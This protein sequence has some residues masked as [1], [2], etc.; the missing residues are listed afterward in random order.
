MN[1]S[2]R[3]GCCI[4]LLLLLTIPSLI[5]GQDKK[6]LNYG[7]S[8]SAYSAIGDS[9][10][11]FW[12]YANT[13]GRVDKESANFITR[14]Y[15]HY[16][17]S[18]DNGTLRFGT[19]IDV[20]SRYS[21]SNS[22]F[23]NE[24][25]GLIGYKFLN[26]KVGR[27]YNTIGLND[28]D[29]TMGSMQVS[30]NATPVPKIELST[31]GFTDIPFTKGYVQFKTMLSHGWLEE[32]RFV[33]NA[34]LHQKYFYLKVDLDNVEL[35]GGGIH[36]V[37][38]GGDHANLGRLPSSFADFVDV[39][40][41]SSASADSNAPGSDITNAIG[42]SVA[43]YDF[44]IKVDAQ[45]FDFKAYRLFYLE[46]RVSTR[47]RSPWDGTWGAGIEF[48]EQDQ[49]VNEILWEHMNTKRQDSF[50]YEPRGSA[51]YYYNGIYRS[52]WAYQGRVL[53]NPLIT[54][55][56]NPN[57]L[58]RGDIANNIIIAH[59]LGLKGQPTDRFH[60]KVFFT[61]SRNYGTVVDQ[62]QESPTIPISE[63]RVDNYS[64]LLKGNY[65]LL[66][67]SGISLTAS[68]AFDIGDLYQSDR[69]GLQL[70]I[71]WNNFLK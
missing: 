62:K 53:G 69:I 26:L 33:R 50:D 54:Y 17:S 47:F 52:G 14:L 19:G 51:S 11:P 30:R 35:I 20:T 41:G 23:F 40:L 48:S 25:Y 34:Y 70:G 42:N 57:F 5:L 22:L 66:P 27:F 44:G 8:T 65:L 15:S 9:E 67:Y 1:F 28:S 13:D 45:N 37:V 71:R 24:L 55:G 64:T 6:S 56:T 49:F 43:A 31:N 10:L 58:G 3:Y 68:V 36:N 61:Y 63:L 4:G 39:V 60:Y 32:N 2:F 46:D 18:N 21:Q 7:I 12:L 59:H 16:S 29:L 38:W